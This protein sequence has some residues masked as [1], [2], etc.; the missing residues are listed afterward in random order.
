MINVK[1]CLYYQCFRLQSRW[2]SCS[3]VGWWKELKIVRTFTEYQN[4]VNM[5]FKIFCERGVTCG[6]KTSRRYRFRCK[7]VKKH[8]ARYAIK[9]LIFTVIVILPFV[10]NNVLDHCNV[11]IWSIFNVSSECKN[12]APNDYKNITEER[13]IGNNA[14]AITKQF[15][16]GIVKQ[17]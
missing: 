4:N 8:R 16:T 11:Y 2:L 14:N 3:S 6:S 12:R 10:F 13:W 17:M 1:L 9:S 15:L 5:N 7:F